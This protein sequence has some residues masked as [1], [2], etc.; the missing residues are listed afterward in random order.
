MAYD[1]DASDGIITTLC[2]EAP[3]DPTASQTP[4][5]YVKADQERFFETALRG[6]KLKLDDLV[7]MDNIF[8]DNLQFAHVGQD[9]NRGSSEDIAGLRRKY[10]RVLKD[11]LINY[12]ISDAVMYLGPAGEEIRNAIRGAMCSAALDAS[13]ISFHEQGSSVKHTDICFQARQT[14]I[15]INQFA[16]VRSLYLMAVKPFMMK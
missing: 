9:D 6:S 12:G 1:L 14:N 2:G 10:N 3:Y 5:I 16:Y 8:W 4:H 11:D 7:C 15:R 13:G